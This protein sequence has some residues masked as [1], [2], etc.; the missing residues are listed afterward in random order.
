MYS[1]QVLDHFQNPRNV[2]GM[3]DASA[4]ARVENP[5][6]GDLMDLYMK[7]DKGRVVAA[8]YRVRGCVTSIACG[9]KLTELISGRTLEE[10][11]ALRREEIVEALG[12]LTPETM[13]GSHLAFDALQQALA[14]LG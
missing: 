12:G 5:A 9:S 14:K 2:G 6:C 10:A 13:Q 7:V 4:T 11:R 3:P 8:R 1:P